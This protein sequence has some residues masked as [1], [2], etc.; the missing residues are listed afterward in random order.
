MAKETILKLSDAYL[1]QD[2]HPMLELQVKVININPAA[3]HEILERCPILKEYSLFIHTIRK[4]QD[5]NYENA[6]ECAIKECIKNNILADY[7]RKKGSE[8]INMLQAEY[9]YETDIEVQR[10]EAFQDGIQSGV[11]Y[12]KVNIIIRLLKKGMDASQIT[13]LLGDNPNVIFHICE[14]A[15]GYAPDYNLDAICQALNVSDKNILTP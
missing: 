15:S 6:Y 5:L 2:E 7:L 11:L 3:N 14:V 10:E 1:I 13:D 8:V 9:D 12:E 4:Y